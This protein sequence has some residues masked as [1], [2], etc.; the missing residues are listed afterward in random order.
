LCSRFPSPL[1]GVAI[2]DTIQE[3]LPNR[4][5]GE[6]NPPHHEVALQE[7]EEAERV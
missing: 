6:N 5:A 2:A 3:S 4:Q 1:L 7:E